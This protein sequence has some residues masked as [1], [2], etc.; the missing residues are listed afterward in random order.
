[1]RGWELLVISGWISAFVLG[2][3]RDDESRSAVRSPVPPWGGVRSSSATPEAAARCEQSVLA[4]W[5]VRGGRLRV[6]GRGS[7]R[8]G[9]T[10]DERTRAHD[11]ALLAGSRRGVADD[12][13]LSND[14]GSVRELVPPAGGARLVGTTAQEETCRA[15]LPCRRALRRYLASGESATRRRAPGSRSRGR[16]MRAA[17]LMARHRQCD[18]VAA[19]PCQVCRLRLP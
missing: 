8:P 2:I 3:D 5:G 1:M 10:Q 17:R 9:S 6:N 18:P 13:T 12:V 7:S 11:V 19:P 16:R 4:F 14:D 15:D